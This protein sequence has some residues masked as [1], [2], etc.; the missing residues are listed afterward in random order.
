MI[1]TRSSARRPASGRRRTALVLGLAL[2]GLVV[3]GCG[4][5]RILRNRLPA[6]HF[7]EREG[8]RWVLFQYEAPQAR[9]VNLCGN[10]DDNSWC[11]TEGT[12]RF[13]HTI[14]MMT[15]ENGDGIW[16]I[17]VPLKP[18]RYSYKYA[19]DYGVRWEPDPSNPLTEDDGYGGNNSILILR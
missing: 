19:L 17:Y 16:E 6:P 9:H 11:G 15:D 14:G 8:E 1:P 13:D 3:I 12:G 10:W 5:S 4:Y 7:V 18:G 2:L